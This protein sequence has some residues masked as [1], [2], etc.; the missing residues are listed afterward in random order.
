MSNEKNE[1]SK[2]KLSIME[3]NL[4][5]YIFNVSK[6]DIDKYVNSLIY[7]N[8]LD[9]DIFFNLIDLLNETLSDDGILYRNS[10]IRN[11]TLFSQKLFDNFYVHNLELKKLD[12]RVYDNT[13][14]ETILYTSYF[15]YLYVL[16]ILSDRKNGKN[17]ISI[18]LKNSKFFNEIVFNNICPHFSTYITD[19]KISDYFCNIKLKSKTNHC[20]VSHYI[21]AWKFK[22]NNSH[23]RISDVCELFNKFYKLK[24]IID[25]NTIDKI[26]YNVLFQIFFSILTMSTYKIN[27]NDLRPANILLHGNYSKTDHFDL[28]IIKTKDE[29]LKYYLPNLGFKIKIIDFGLTHSEFVDNLQNYKAVNYCISKEAGIYPYYSDVYDQHYFINDILTRNIDVISPEIYLFLKS[30]VDDKYIG[31]NKTNKNICEYWRLAFPFTISHFISKLKE[32]FII[33]ID[34]ENIL[35]NKYK[36]NSIPSNVQTIIKDICVTTLTYDSDNKL[37]T[38]M[39]LIEKILD[40]VNCMSDCLKSNPALLNMLIDP[41]DNNINSILKPLDII[42]KFAMYNVDINQDLILNTYEL[43]IL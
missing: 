15:C 17:S 37:E 34:S 35:S 25:Q 7:N 18:E 40:F 19:F 2:D 36:I 20:I 16:K 4:T 21:N 9:N 23:H 24:D 10:F 8:D 26:L 22:L 38:N 6:S 41:L 3:N 1:L 14:N 42:K 28:Y 43:S 31:T 13:N 32:D 33:D 30:I 5:N 27:H 11:L 12:T 29:I 39:I